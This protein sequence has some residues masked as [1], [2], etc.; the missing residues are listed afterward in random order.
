[1]MKG[2]RRAQN[3]TAPDGLEPAE[4]LVVS[5]AQELLR[6]RKASDATYAATPERFGLK[7]LVDLTVL[8]GYYTML[9]YIMHALEVD[10]EPGMA[11]LLPDQAQ[12]PLISPRPPTSTSTSRYLPLLP[13]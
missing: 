9:A 11:P 10:L 1:M 5:Y 8:V 13:T 6:D 4:A 3:D 12:S 2:H 7:T